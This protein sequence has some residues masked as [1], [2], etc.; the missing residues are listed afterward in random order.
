MK[1]GKFS[2]I[3]PFRQN[4]KIREKR[5]PERYFCTF[6]EKAHT[7]KRVSVIAPDNVIS[8]AKCATRTLGIFRTCREKHNLI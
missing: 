2:D 3:L 6:G 1:T 4:P 8:K 5:D 7:S